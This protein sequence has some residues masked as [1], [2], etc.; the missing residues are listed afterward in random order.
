MQKWQEIGQR[1]T[2]IPIFIDF[3][4]VQ[5]DVPHSLYSIS[6]ISMPP[7]R[8]IGDILCLSC[9][10]VC[11]SVVIFNLRYNIWT[12]RDRNFIF[13]M[14]TPLMMPFQLTPRSMTLWPWLWPWRLKYLFRLCCH[15]GHTVMFHNH[16]LTLAAYTSSARSSEV[17]RNSLL[18]TWVESD[19]DKNSNKLLEHLKSPNFNHISSIRKVL[20]KQY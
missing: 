9:L 12:V 7:D 17:L 11:L 2:K 14:H 20:L 10:F 5:S 3:L 8:M 16:P 15:R 4:P 6:F 1:F 19:L 13:G 18:K